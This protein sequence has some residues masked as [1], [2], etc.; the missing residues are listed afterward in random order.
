MPESAARR[1]YFTIGHST[2]AIDAFAACLQAAGVTRVI[3]VRSI[4]RSRTNPQYNQD[5]LPAALAAYGIGYEHMASLGGRRGL[6]RGIDPRLNGFWHNRS[7]HHYADYALQPAFREGLEQL[8]EFG[9]RECCAIMCSEA[10]WWR[11]H[12]RI[13]S[14]HLLAAGET[15]RHLMNGRIEDARLTPGAQAHADGSVTYPAQSPP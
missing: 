11:C 9:Q 6:Q 7:F 8:R 4:P 3:D 5:R 2:L 12:R 13:I 14:D 10:V 1:P 15:V